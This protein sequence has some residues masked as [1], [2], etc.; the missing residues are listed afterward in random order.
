MAKKEKVPLST[1]LLAGGTAGLAEALVCHPLDTI[2]VRMQLS[3]GRKGTAN[4]PLGF[5]A[6]GKQI[7]A[8]ETPLGLYK[9]LGAVVTGIV[10]KMAIR[11]ASFEMYKG[12]LANED[13]ALSPGKIFVAGLGAGA[14]EAVIVVNPMEVVKIRLQAQQ[15]S[16]ADPDATP[17]YRNAA[18][19]LYTIIREEGFSTLY[20]GVA[21]T[22]LRQA[23]NQGVNF[24][25]YQYFKKWAMEFQPEYSAK[26]ELP[27]YQTM[28][29]GLISG[30]MG[31]FSNAPIDTIKTRIQKASKEPGETAFSRFQKVAADMFKNEG[32]S[33]FYKGITPRVMRVAPGQAIVF[34]V[35]ER[36]KRIIDTL[37]TEDVTPE[38]FEA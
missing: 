3:R 4:K 35:Y 32:I 15:H 31:P 24:T 27:S 22:A 6:T 37:K 17:R 19:A 7:V 16:L 23:T 1:H 9:G 36:V 5:F 14:T 2:K 33:A 26:G 30:A 34:A 21:L 38:E 20:R 10:P 11:F 28:V 25:A 8:R 12:W 18:H 29:I 13:G